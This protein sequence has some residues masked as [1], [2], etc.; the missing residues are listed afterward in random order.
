M[1]ILKHTDYDSYDC[2]Y[3]YIYMCMDILCVIICISLSLFCWRS[4]WRNRT[5]PSNKDLAN[6][7]ATC[8]SFSPT[9]WITSIGRLGKNGL[10]Y[11]EVLMMM[12]NDYNNITLLFSNSFLI[13]LR[14]FGVKIITLRGASLHVATR[15]V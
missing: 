14:C 5:Q 10:W 4:L 12:H 11:Y 8:C 2:I 1:S 9:S 3:I 13:S 15:G 6:W 7:R